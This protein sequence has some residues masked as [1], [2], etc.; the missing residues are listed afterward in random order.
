MKKTCRTL[1]LA[2]L[3]MMVSG[4]AATM[5]ASDVYWARSL[6]RA[7]YQNTS[8]GVTA[9]DRLHTVRQVVDQDARSLVDDIDYIFMWERPSRLSRWHNR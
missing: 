7:R 9:A 8:S 3:A 1:G 2:A 4:C 5:S 6:E